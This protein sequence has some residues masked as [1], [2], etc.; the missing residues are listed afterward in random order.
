MCK[1]SFTFITPT[2]KRSEAVL[3]RCLDSVNGQTYRNW[4][5]IVM[6]DDV[7]HDGH[8]SKEVMNTYSSAQRQFFLLGQ[9]S[10]NS[11]NTPRQRCIEMCD[12][13]Y[14]VFLDDDNVIFPNYLDV[15]LRALQ[16]DEQ[17]DMTIC[18]II[19]LGPLPPWLGKMAVLDGKPPVLQNI[20]SLQIAVKTPLMKQIGWQVDKGYMADG[21]T[22]QKL[23][24]N[25][26]YKHVD[27]ILGVHL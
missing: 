12:T 24:E 22:I 4:K 8:V 17:P 10:N 27:E 13:D 20:D 19:H 23:A 3:R 7:T 5:Q 1:M 14:I 2:F 21:Y 26:R 25:C 11:G 6:I 18:K 9:R 15:M 16:S